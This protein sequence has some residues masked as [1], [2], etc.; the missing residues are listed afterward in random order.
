MTVDQPEFRPGKSDKVSRSN[1]QPD[2]FQEPPPKRPRSDRP[3]GGGSGGGDVDLKKVP[4]STVDRRVIRSHYAFYK[5]LIHEEKEEL[6]IGESNRFGKIINEVDELF[7]NV[8][9][10]REQ[11]ADAETLLSMADTL[12]TTARSY[13]K[14]GLT[15]SDFLTSLFREF[16]A[17]IGRKVGND[18]VSI[19]WNGPMDTQLKPRKVVVRK[20]RTKLTGRAAKPKQVEDSDSEHQKDTEK[21][22]R[23]MFDILRAEKRN[24]KSVRLENLILNRTSFAQ[25]VENLFALSFL[26]KDGRAQITIN[27][28][29]THLVSPRNAPHQD[30]VSSGEVLIHHFVFRPDFKDWKLM[31]DSVPS[32]DELMPHRCQEGVPLSQSNTVPNLSP[33]GIPPSATTEVQSSR[34]TMT[35]EL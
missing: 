5:N 6:F 34:K 1:Q 3:R 27:D 31:V 23:T 13:L 21:N 28:Q 15:P 17:S 33:V 19:Q 24:K 16:G 8:S 18:S 20:K 12:V 9:N 14:D 2:Y 29:G 26:V 10:T 35:S 30:L 25:T 22:M 32:G 11:V 7:E 4:Q